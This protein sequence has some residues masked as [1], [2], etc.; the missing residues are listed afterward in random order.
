MHFVG[1]SASSHRCSIPNRVL[2][3][4]RLRPVSR[5]DWSLQIAPHSAKVTASNTTSH[6][7]SREKTQRAAGKR[8][9]YLLR[10]EPCSCDGLVLE[11]AQS[12]PVSQP[13]LE[14]DRH[15]DLQVRRR[16]PQHNSNRSMNLTAD[17]TTTGSHHLPIF[18]QLNVCS[19]NVEKLAVFYRTLCAHGRSERGDECQVQHAFATNNHK[20][21]EP[22][23]LP[24]QSSHA[25][26]L[27]SHVRS[28]RSA[29]NMNILQ[30]DKRESSRLR[31]HTL[32]DNAC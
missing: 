3:F 19:A 11:E 2:C 30:T 14:E 28:A 15:I 10:E 22:E 6:S 13:A 7:P 17:R 18:A 29:A 4:R 1:S 31:V 21:L 9:N 20:T 27:P 24:P 8:K 16:L 32:F 26:S 23:N 5:L 25:S 12:S